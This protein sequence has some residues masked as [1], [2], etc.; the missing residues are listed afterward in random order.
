MDK[1]NE[2]FI[3]LLADSVDSC[4][5]VVV[6]TKLDL[7]S[8]EGRQVK[9]SEGR[10]LAEQQLAFYLER[11]QKTNP[12][13][14]L[15]DIDGKK[16]YFETSAKDNIKINELFEKIQS[17][18]LPQLQKLAPTKEGRAKSIR[19]DDPIPSK[20]KGGHGQGRGSGRCCG[21]GG[22]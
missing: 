20:G 22:D 19:L 4:L 8:S 21:G 5:T 3:P 2:I 17:I 1:L 16:L 18:V 12:N 9:E 15:K 11:A 7:V 13:S 10:E 6:G 14:Y